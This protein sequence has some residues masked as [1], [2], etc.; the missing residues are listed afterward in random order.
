MRNRFPTLRAAAMIGFLLAPGISL[1]D[2]QSLYQRLGG[3]DA[4][5]AVTKDVAGRLMEDDKLGRFW[6]HRGGDGIEREVQ[7]IVDYIANKSGGPLYYRGRDMKL[8]HIG[9]RIDD[10]DWDRMMTHLSTTLDKF[11]VPQRERQD[12]VAFFDSLKTDI[13]EVK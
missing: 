11:D 6:A 13:V 5:A 3:Y 12:V 4:I 2:D 1:A 10:E 8:A 7:L 9:M